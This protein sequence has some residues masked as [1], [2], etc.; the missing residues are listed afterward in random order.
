MEREA[1]LCGFLRVVRAMLNIFLEDK[2]S[3]W[4]VLSFQI[5]SPEIA[6]KIVILIDCYFHNLLSTWSSRGTL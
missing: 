1:I 2:F 3:L 6:V 5:C 4:L